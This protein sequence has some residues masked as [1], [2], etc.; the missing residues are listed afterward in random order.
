MNNYRRETLIYLKFKIVKYNT[1]DPELIGNVLKTCCFAYCH[2][3]RIGLLIVPSAHLIV[4]LISMWRWN[5]SR[6]SLYYQTNKIYSIREYIEE[7]S[8]TSSIN[9]M[10]TCTWKD[11]D[12]EA[13]ARWA[14]PEG[15][16]FKSWHCPN[17]PDQHYQVRVVLVSNRERCTCPG[18]IYLRFSA[19]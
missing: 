15:V 19:P 8:W 11:I 6:V 14:S 10:R 5:E 7:A 3:F 16:A 4:S 1:I 13:T 2:S 18:A 17:L 9:Q 12:S